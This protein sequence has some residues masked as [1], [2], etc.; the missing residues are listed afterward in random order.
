MLLPVLYHC[1]RCSRD[2]PTPGNCPACSPKAYVALKPVQGEPSGP[3]GKPCRKC[4]GW[5]R[6][7]RFVHE[8]GCREVKE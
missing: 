5:M 7:G 1:P 8:P 4:N 6:G 3:A 2:F